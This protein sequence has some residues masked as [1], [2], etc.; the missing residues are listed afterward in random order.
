MLTT[1]LAGLGLQVIMDVASRRLELKGGWRNY[2]WIATVLGLLVFVLALTFDRHEKITGWLVLA[3][4]PLAWAIW[5]PSSRREWL[6]A[7]GLLLLACFSSVLSPP[8]T[9]PFWV[10]EYLRADNL[11]SHRVLRR[12]A[13]LPDIG[14]YRV[15]VLDSQFRPLEWGSN[16]SYYGIRTFYLNCT[17]VPYD[18]FREMFDEQAVNFRKLRGAKYFVCGQNSMPFDPNARLLFTESGYRVY[19]VSDPM[20]PYTLVHKV[21]P[22]ANRQVFQNELATG[23]DYE[24][25]AALEQQK[26]QASFPPLRTIER[27]GAP[28]SATEDFVEPIFQTP[29]L[30]GVLAN[31]TQP[32]LLI[33]NER[34]SDAWHARVNSQ[35]AKVLRANFTQPAVALPAGRNYVEFE[36]K[37][38]LFWA[39]LILQRVTFLILVLAGMWMVWRSYIRSRPI[40]T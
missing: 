36:Y 31:S 20:E 38:M 21:V 12:L 23:F 37:P 29:N 2:F 18:Q 7:S 32:G 4:V 11:K 40:A 39:L 16:A 5:R 30:F 33:L 17:P 24:H 6:V 22:S 15:V 10:S 25:V 8:G 28:V 34:W 13:Q 9:Q 14:H 1:L 35:P 26:G 3:V 27:G 19:E